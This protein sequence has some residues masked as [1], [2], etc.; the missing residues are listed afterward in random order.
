MNARELEA[1]PLLAFWVCPLM[2]LLQR[3][4]M[5]WAA[6]V[7]YCQRIRSVQTTDWAHLFE[8][9]RLQPSFFGPSPF[10]ASPSWALFLIFKQRFLDRRSLGLH[11]LGSFVF[12]T[13]PCFGAFGFAISARP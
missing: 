1:S 8:P 6:A 4:P 12:Y 10:W 7:E 3:E 2:E 5:D 13:K 11:F 9:P